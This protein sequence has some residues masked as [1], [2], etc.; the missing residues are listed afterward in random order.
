MVKE[1]LDTQDIKVAV[2]EIKSAGK[3]SEKAEEKARKSYD[4]MRM[5]KTNFNMQL[6]TIVF[7]ETKMK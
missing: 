4:Y 5:E 6:N 3:S 7:K 2:V 1:A